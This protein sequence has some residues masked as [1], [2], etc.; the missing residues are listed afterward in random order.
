[1]TVIE[2]TAATRSR[3]LAL[4]CGVALIMLKDDELHWSVLLTGRVET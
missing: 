1:M 2:T 4:S 3:A